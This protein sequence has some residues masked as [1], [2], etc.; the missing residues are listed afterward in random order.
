MNERYQYTNI[1]AEETRAGASS[2][3]LVK[4]QRCRCLPCFH[5]CQYVINGNLMNGPHVPY[6]V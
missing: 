1:N 2:C 3:M 6:T 4:V 5:A